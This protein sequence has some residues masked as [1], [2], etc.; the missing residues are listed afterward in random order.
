MSYSAPVLRHRFFDENGDPLAGGKLWTYQAGTTTPRVTWKDSLNA[1]ENENPIILD[2]EGYCDI[3]YTT[4]SYKFVL[5]TADD[6]EIWSRDGISQPTGGGGGGSLPPGGA[7]YAV[8]QKLTGDDGDAD[9]VLNQAVGFSQTYGETLNLIGIQA[10][11]DYI[12]DITYTPPTISL[13]ASGNVLREKGTAVTSTTLTAAIVKKSDPIAEVRFYMNPSTLL[14]TQ[15]SGGAI[16]NGGNSTYNWTGSF[17]DNTTF[18]AEVDDDGA[19]G[20]PTTVQSTTTFSFVYVYYFGSDSPGLSAA[21][22][23]TLT[24][25]IRNNTNSVLKTFTPSNGDVFYFAYPAAYGALTSIKDE[26]DFETIG[27]WTASTQNITGLDGNAV[28]Y[29]IYEFNN[30]VVAGSYDYTFIK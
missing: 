29:R 7:Q 8:L 14:D 12:F 20:G 4:G 24:K 2:S 26:N 11:F 1:Q 25:D 10:M 28:S 5:M 21:Q 22:V 9:W 30:P 15:T 6:V 3:Y 23:G 17:S 27:D 18:R 19:T 13:S 16:P